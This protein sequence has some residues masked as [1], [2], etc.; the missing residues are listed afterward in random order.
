MSTQY[1]FWP[2]A[3]KAKSTSCPNGTTTLEGMSMAVHSLLLV[4]SM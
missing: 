3:W 1:T 2:P 4:A